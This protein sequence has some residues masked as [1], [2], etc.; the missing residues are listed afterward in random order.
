M[1][2][3]NVPAISTSLHKLIN[4]E[5]KALNPFPLF[6]CKTSWDF[7]KKRKCDNILNVWKMTFQASNLK[8]KQFLNLLN[9]NNIIIK[10]FYTKGRSWLKV[11]GH[12]NSLCVHAVRAI[13]NH[14]PTSKYRLRFFPKKEFKCLYRS[15]PIKLRYHI[16]H[17]YSRFNGY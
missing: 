17:E 5:T 3:R 12:L 10:P 9:N 7:S 2:S 1:N 4:K 15:Y 6:P 11:F 14:T 16:L 8:G 13:T